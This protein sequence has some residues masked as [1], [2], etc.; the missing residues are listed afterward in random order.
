MGRRGNIATT[1]RSTGVRPMDRQETPPLPGGV[2]CSYP[3]WENRNRCCA[4]GRRRVLREP[5]GSHSDTSLCAPHIPNG[6]RTTSSEVVRVGSLVVWPVCPHPV[7]DRPVVFGRD[8]CLW[9]V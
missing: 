1:I 3:G 8:G 6:T 2:S 4:G 7:N 9:R 5:L